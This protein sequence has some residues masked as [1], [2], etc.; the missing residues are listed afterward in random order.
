[1]IGNFET[2]QFRGDQLTQDFSLTR[3]KSKAPYDST[4]AHRH[5]YHEIF[6]FEHGGGQHTIDFQSHP[7]KA[8]AVHLVS[9]HKLHLVQR[10]DGSSGYV[11]QFR[12]EFI[13]GAQGLNPAFMRECEIL[14]MD[15]LLFGE[16]YDITRSIDRELHDGPKLVN[17]IVRTQLRLILLKCQQHVHDH[18]DQ[19]P[20][21]LVK[22]DLYNHFCQLVDQHYRDHRNIEFYASTLGVSQSGLTKKIKQLTGKSPTQFIH[23]RVLLE[24]KRLVYFDDVSNKEISFHLNFTDPAHLAHFFK[25]RTGQTLSDFRK[26]H[27]PG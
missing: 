12:D 15:T 5:D 20:Q 1:M 16:L 19:F 2:H 6:L 9:N 23:D 24:I 7:I 26:T 22:D 21:Q 17:E 13:P 11:L 3:L 27:R 8:R 18:P 14:N 10:H 4:I 25:S